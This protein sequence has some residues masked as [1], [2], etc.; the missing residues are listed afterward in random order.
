M[1]RALAC[2][3]GG[4]GSIPAAAIDPNESFSSRVLGGKK[5]SVMIF[6]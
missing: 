5:D 6:S 3:A 2:N 4:P 1:D